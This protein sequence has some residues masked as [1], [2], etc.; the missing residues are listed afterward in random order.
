[1]LDKWKKSL[2]FVKQLR[3][4]LNVL[5]NFRLSI[6]KLMM[7]PLGWF[8]DN[9]KTILGGIPSLNKPR[10]GDKVES[11]VLLVLRLLK[12]S[13]SIQV[14]YHLT[15]SIE[16]NALEKVV[17]WPGDV[18]RQVEVGTPR[19][20]TDRDYVR[21]RVIQ[22]YNYGF[23]YQRGLKTERYDRERVVSLL[24]LQNIY[25]DVSLKYS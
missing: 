13:S 1:M 9:W 25:Q 16:G 18:G 6:R 14:G 21:N 12:G 22:P 2:I 10:K 3:E 5:R 15:F 8:W 17:G 19:R 24:S 23:Q 20:I 7:R 11:L 4:T